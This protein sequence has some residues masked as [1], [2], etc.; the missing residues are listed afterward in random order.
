MSL[1]FNMLS[2]FIIA[3]LPRS[4]VQF[5]CSVVS[6]S[7]T[8]WT[9]ARQATQS[10]TDSWNLLK[11]ISLNRWCHLTISSS[12]IPFSSCLPSSP[13]SG[14]FPVSKFFTS[15]GQSIGV[16]ALASVLPMNIQ[17]WFPLDWLVRSPCSPRDSQESSPTPQFKSISSV[18]L[19]LLYGPTLTSMAPG[20]TI[21]LTR[22]TFVGKVISLLFNT[23]SRFV[24]AFFPPLSITW[25]CPFC[26]STL[27]TYIPF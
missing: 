1:L 26:S 17:D 25:A 5:S 11:L 8:P 14:S 13:A 19:S 23:L 24:I 22:W 6:D 27:Q 7:A 21:A 15:D 18:A 16:S 12:V 4:S 10:I 2:R 20:K 3:F 9:A